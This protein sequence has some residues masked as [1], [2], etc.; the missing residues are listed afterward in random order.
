MLAG[1]TPR[2]YR[3]LQLSLLLMLSRALTRTRVRVSRYHIT[4]MAG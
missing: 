1:P 3:L 2:Q 4:R